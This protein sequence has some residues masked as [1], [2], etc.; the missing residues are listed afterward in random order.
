MILMVITK[1]QING[2]VKSKERIIKR[3]TSSLQL[4]ERI[5]K[6]TLNKNGYLYV[7]LYKDKKKYF[8]PIHVLVANHFLKND[9]QLK[10]V[11]HVDGNKLNNFSDNLE[12]CT[13]KQNCE[14]SII[15]GL[16]GFKTK[17]R[18]TTSTYQGV[19]YI[20]ARNRWLTQII[21]KGVLLTRK[22][23][24]SE[25]EAAEHYDTIVITHS[26]K[27]PLNFYKDTL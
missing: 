9:S 17:C 12:W 2:K 3:S 6:P 19:S 14:H 1:F 21:F 8:K 27:R 15:N 26:L 20:T 10:V 13:Q 25:K 7:T 11:N 23:F 5:L 4:T 18:K 22:T 16:Q 24:K